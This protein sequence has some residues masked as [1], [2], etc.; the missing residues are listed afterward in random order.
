MPIRPRSS[1][2]FVFPRKI[3]ARPARPGGG[4]S[5]LDRVIKII[6]V[7]AA[8][9]GIFG[10][11]PLAGEVLQYPKYSGFI[12]LV[13]LALVLFAASRL[14]SG[15][16]ARLF[17]G[18][19]LVAIALLVLFL[20]A[21]F[22]A[23]PWAAL[24]G[25]P[26]RSGLSF[27]GAGAFAAFIFLTYQYAALSG[28][29]KI[30][31][32]LGIALG[33]A[34]VFF[35]VRVFV[36][37]PFVFGRLGLSV[38]SLYPSETGAAA[39]AALGLALGAL[40]IA[41]SKIAKVGWSV[42][43]LV[44]LAVI[45]LIGLPRVWGEV[46]LVAALVLAFAWRGRNFRSLAPIAAA[47]IFLAAIPL[48][49][50]GTPS[51]VR[52]ALPAEFTLSAGESWSVARSALASPKNFLLGSGP[53]G[54]PAAFAAFRPASLNQS[55]VFGAYALP[56][57]GI[58]FYLLVEAG[59]L[60]TMLALALA[61]AGAAVAVRATGSDG[62][63]RP[64]LFALAPAVVAGLVGPFSFALAALAAVLFFLL[65]AL[66]APT[67]V[68]EKAPARAAY[69]AAL[70]ALLAVAVLGLGATARAVLAEN[71]YG[72]G[73]R[74]FAKSDYSAAAELSSR[75]A[76]IQPDD[77]RYAFGRAQADVML[78]RVSNFN[79]DE[80]A[81]AAASLRL[82]ADKNTDLVE[83][84]TALT[85]LAGTLYGQSSEADKITVEAA[86][87]A[88]QLEPGNPQIA[89]LA[90]DVR[91]AA[92]DAAGAALRYARAITAK[93]NYTEAYYHWV[94]L[95]SAGK[96]V[97]GAYELASQVL[98]NAPY[99]KSAIALF[100]NAAFARGDASDIEAVKNVLGQAAARFPDDQDLA[101]AFSA[102]S[103]PTKLQQIKD[104][105]KGLAATAATPA[106][107]TAS[108][109]KE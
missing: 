97:N 80:V 52:L 56:A 82:A 22:S 73:A 35:L 69:L 102:V 30:I 85:Q 41:E 64:L 91:V 88:E 42:L 67:V 40:G 46:A 28:I 99:D 109:T 72:A 86:A 59:L 57:A 76:T 84:W 106:A 83:Y 47:L 26:E 58:V 105:F 95:L 74:A 16:P 96:D 6:L 81:A 92:G 79:K 7:A 49:I 8:A 9:W 24:L 55:A 51:A 39:A 66:A 101:A 15:E 61:A 34:L 100:V 36:P 14:L 25:G 10:A 53:G 104:S 94:R 19:W 70:A 65:L 71:F 48:A 1:Q 23:N 44:A 60:F 27:A 32:A 37:L 43:A 62:L 77:E 38:F 21:I 29:K 31:P 89:L 13:A 108:S 50:F 98:R 4:G 90:G 103:D 54:Y 17:R 107:S 33:V 3:V 75:A 68:W 87:R 11:S 78:A 45:T 5:F 18:A 12:L 2:A 20:A 63:A 93:P